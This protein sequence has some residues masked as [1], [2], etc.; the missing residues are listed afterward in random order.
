ML[1]TRHLCPGC[2][3]RWEDTKKPCSR[4][5]FSWETGEPGG[6]ELP[7]FTVLGGRYLLG[8][9]IGAG[10][11][12]ISYIALDLTEESLLAV[13]E[14]FPAGM[15]QR[16]GAEV[17]PEEDA[18]EED[19]QRARESFRREAELLARFA[20]TEGIVTYRDYLEENGTAYLVMD[21]VEGPNLK[22]ALRERGRPFNQEEA[23]ELMKPILLAVDAMHR[24]WVI[25][26][27][28]S[29]ENLIR[30]PDGT[31]TLIDFGAA[32]EFSF[33]E[34]ENLTVIVKRGYAPEEQ[35]HSGSRQGPWTDLYACCAVLYQLVSGILPQDAAGRRETDE[36]VPLKDLG[37]LQVT[38]EFSDA[39]AKGMTIS[40]ADR[41][42]SIRELM[43]DLYPEEEEVCV[44]E[45]K[46]GAGPEI[47][48][49]AQPEAEAEPEP[50]PESELRPE[51]ASEPE[52]APQPEPGKESQPQPPAGMTSAEE[53]SAGETSAGE[54]SAGG[55]S[56]EKRH[57]PFVPIAAGAAVLLLLA[58]AFGLDW[59][60]LRKTDGALETAQTQAEA[61]EASA[62]QPEEAGAEAA[63][64][65]DAQA[66]ENTQDAQASGTAE[67]P[68][69]AGQNSDE[70]EETG[71]QE[72]LPLIY[73]SVQEDGTTWI[74]TT[75]QTYQSTP[76]ASGSLDW[77]AEAKVSSEY[78]F[79][80]EEITVSTTYDGTDGTFS[81]FW[82]Y[83]TEGRKVLGEQAGERQEFEYQGDTGVSRT[84][85]EAGN[86]TATEELQ[87]EDGR[88]VSC[89]YEAY[90]PE[91]GQNVMEY[92]EMEYLEDG[93]QV[94]TVT[95]S[96]EKE[97]FYGVTT[98]YYTA[99]GSL[100]KRTM[101]LF[102][103]DGSKETAS[104]E[105]SFQP[106]GDGRAGSMLE[107]YTDPQG[108][109]GLKVTEYTYDE[110]G[111]QLTDYTWS[112]QSGYGTL[113]SYIYSEFAPDENGVFQPTG[114]TSG[115][116]EPKLP[117]SL[118]QD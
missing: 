61:F 68:T 105:Y 70:P 6:K 101:E 39:V 99:K 53:A 80:A 95:T 25:H 21:Y 29:P 14:F 45:E 104:Y 76:D 1:D 34:Q 56:S 102:Y 42:P 103:G 72:P 9:R 32:R 77:A 20:G 10:G 73:G 93:S 36:L 52:P 69:A 90:A 43:R 19:Y 113:N 66:G 118:L 22:Q 64:D 96:Y 26:R 28:I 111:N 78:T 110:Y 117:A 91:L 17:V 58:L 27:D 112:A 8:K 50:E 16:K 40:A 60:G 94:E 44:P 23:L 67:E 75:V 106:D 87:Y 97:T 89:D 59:F 109:V 13:K 84:Y 86:V 107:T 55:T 62:G 24:K 83:D 2:M 18:D 108:Q 98:S 92:T 11:F 63:E 38:E 30:K 79:S 12:G 15:A 115:T 49:E 82:I 3:S 81:S 116:A 47:E 71:Q 46:V 57:F 48:L 51:P 5:G 7:P 33:T 74:N 41:Y 4:C 88:L 114:R 54:T 100:T 85:D 35:Y 31:L 65:A 37:G